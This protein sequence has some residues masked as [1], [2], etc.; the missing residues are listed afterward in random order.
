MGYRPRKKPVPSEPVRAVIDSFTH[1]GR[2]VGR[3][4]GKPVFIDGALPGEEVS[5]IYTD[6][7]RDYAEGKVAA[8][9]TAA[10]GRVEPHCPS[11]GV[12]GGCSF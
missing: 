7:R 1:D 3:V 12:C 11:F 5:F 2:G 8:V 9:L 10:P 6:I 4:D